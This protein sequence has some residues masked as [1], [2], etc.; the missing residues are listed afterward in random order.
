MQALRAVP[1][2]L[3][4]QHQTYV[5]PNLSSSSY[6]FIRHDAVR[7]PLQSPYDGPYKVI[8]R[9]DKFFTVDINGRQDTIS[10]DRIKPA[11][12]DDGNIQS[13]SS[14]SQPS[15]PQPSHIPSPLSST[16]T[17]HSGCRVCWPAH[18]TDYVP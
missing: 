16:Q 2:R 14:P 10:L 17:T 4:T 9:N 11:Y 18:L 15:S 12:L 3:A 5:S 1:P 8:R 7:K 13:A 6:V